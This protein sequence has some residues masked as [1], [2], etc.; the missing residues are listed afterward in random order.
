VHVLRSLRA[1]QFVLAVTAPRRRLVELGRTVP[2]RLPKE[3]RDPG[4][5]RD[6]TQP[7]EPVRPARPPAA[8]QAQPRPLAAPKAGS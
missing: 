5:P 3:K 4:R 2:G 8:A 6:A 1:A 7:R